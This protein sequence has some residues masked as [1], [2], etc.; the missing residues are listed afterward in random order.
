M[1][2]LLSDSAF[3]N[4]NGLFNRKV[5]LT[6]D[7]FCQSFKFYLKQ[8]SNDFVALER[9]TNR[10]V[11]KRGFRVSTLS[12]IEVPYRLLGN[13]AI[14]IYS[15]GFVG[16]KHLY[17]LCSYERR[18]IG[19]PLRRR[20]CH[21]LASTSVSDYQ[22]SN[23]K[24]GTIRGR[25]VE[26]VQ[27]KG[28]RTNS[29]KQ[30]FNYMYDGRILNRYDFVNPTPFSLYDGIEKAYADAVNGYRYWVLPNR[31]TPIKII[32]NKQYNTMKNTRNKVRL[33]ESQLHNVIKE[34]VKKL[35]TEDIYRN[36]HEMIKKSSP[37]T[38]KM[39]DMFGRLR[40]VLNE[41]SKYAV[42]QGIYS[43][44]S[45]TEHVIRRSNEIKMILL[46]MFDETDRL[47]NN[48]GKHLYSSDRDY[49]NRPEFQLP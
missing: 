7:S 38:Q 47:E 18:E 11:L 42:Q 16:L 5:Y 10:Y 49:K 35:L 21:I 25:R 41:I 23:L 17:Q 29:G 26:V 13:S 48:W 1:R 28:I 12:A 39:Y 32:E 6:N 34:S 20:P 3:K 19:K 31:R 24:G 22:P 33:T 44:D 4:I 15:I 46:N 14:L 8:I 45:S 36:T 30:V 43:Y 37:H 2:V 9:D 40:D 27:R